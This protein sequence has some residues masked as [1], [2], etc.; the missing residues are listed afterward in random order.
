MK[1]SSA[2]SRASALGAAST[3]CF[4]RPLPSC[5]V[6]PQER[7][8]DIV[9]VGEILIHRRRLD[10]AGRSDFGHRDAIDSALIEQFPGSIENPAALTLAVSMVCVCRFL[11]FFPR[12]V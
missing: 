9:L 7:P 4:A 2:V 8:D 6:S 11:R 3:L 10:P 1:S 5:I 12:H